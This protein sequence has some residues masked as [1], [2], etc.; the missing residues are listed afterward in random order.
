M[1]LPRQ[2]HR[3]FVESAK[4]PV[5]EFDPECGAIYVRF[6]DRQVAKTLERSSEGMVITIDVDKAGEVV[7]I[8]G[9]G[10]DEFSLSGLLKAA[11][12]RAENVDFSKARFRGT[13]RN[14]SR[15]HEYAT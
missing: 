6:R 15:E 2:H 14:V 7:G 13:P 11:N 1:S 5:I 9:L 3:L 4:P 12:V 8:E 10:F